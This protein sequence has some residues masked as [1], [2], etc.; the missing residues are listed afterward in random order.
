MPGKRGVPSPP[1]P[2]CVSSSHM[3]Q[4]QYRTVPVANGVDARAAENQ[5][6]THTDTHT[7]K[8]G[9]EGRRTGRRC[10]KKNS[11]GSVA[12]V[13]KRLFITAAFCQTPLLWKPRGDSNPCQTLLRPWMQRNGPSWSHAGWTAG[14]RRR[15][16]VCGGEG[17]ANG[18]LDLRLHFLPRLVVIGFRRFGSAALSFCPPCGGTRSFCEWV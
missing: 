18:S 16:S 12:A 15:L 1:P 6:I 2:V 5:S 17:G 10:G 7:H 4:W 3:P 14:N 11:L 8:S 9:G 13:F